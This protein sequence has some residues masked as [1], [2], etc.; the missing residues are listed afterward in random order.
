[1]SALTLAEAGIMLIH[2]THI[3]Q[4]CADIRDRIEPVHS[5]TAARLCNGISARAL[6]IAKHGPEYLTEAALTWVAADTQQRGLAAREIIAMALRAGSPAVKAI[7][8]CH[9]L[10]AGATV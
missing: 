9:P 3:A 10:C 5:Y 4:Q 6:S 8:D 2:K 7:H 1:M